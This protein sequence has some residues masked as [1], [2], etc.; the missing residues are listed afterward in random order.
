MLVWMQLGSS[1]ADVLESVTMYHE[2]LCW[3]FLAYPKADASSRYKKRTLQKLSQARRR[4]KSTKH[5]PDLLGGI[6]TL[7]VSE[8]CNSCWKSKLF[9]MP[10]HSLLLKHENRILKT[11]WQALSQIALALQNSL[12]RKP[13]RIQS[14]ESAF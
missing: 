2:F 7:P 5:S 13:Y 4:K 11:K 8:K 12:G 10:P 1:K 14:P 3:I 6:L 9:K